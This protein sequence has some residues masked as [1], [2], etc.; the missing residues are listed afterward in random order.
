MKINVRE[1]TEKAANV[2]FD[3]PEIRAGQGLTREELRFLHQRGLVTTKLIAD[4]TGWYL[5]WSAAEGLKK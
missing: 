5:L 2:F 1:L 3:H 4:P